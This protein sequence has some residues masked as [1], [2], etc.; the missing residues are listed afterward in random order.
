MLTLMKGDEVVETVEMG[1]YEPLLLYA[2]HPDL[3]Q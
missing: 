2:W 1:S 3:A